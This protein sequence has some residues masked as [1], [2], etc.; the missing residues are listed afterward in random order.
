MALSRRLLEPAYQLLR[1]S[2]VRSGTGV[3][4]GQGDL[5]LQMPGFGGF[6]QIGEGLDGIL[7]NALATAV[8]QGKAV[9][10]V[11]ITLFRGVL[12]SRSG[13]FE[14]SAPEG[15]RRCMGVGPG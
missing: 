11:A 6:L 10:G 8:Q 4:V 13:G 7:G 5:R 3:E 15:V 9:Q 12:P 1:G 2:R 14:I